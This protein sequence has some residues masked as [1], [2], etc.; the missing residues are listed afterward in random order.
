[1]KEIKLKPRL[2][3][4]L[5]SFRDT[6]NQKYWQEDQGSGSSVNNAIIRAREAE[7]N[8]RKYLKRV[9]K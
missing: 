1:M 3:D 2:E 4:L 8:L 7:I 5:A 6:S 9:I